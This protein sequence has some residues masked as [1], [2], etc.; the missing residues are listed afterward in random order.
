MAA[1]IGNN[2]TRVDPYGFLG[3]G[4]PSDSNIFALFFLSAS[5][6]GNR[7]QTVVVLSTTVETGC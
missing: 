3:A 5:T 7:E 2:C 6:Y 4:L 1:Q